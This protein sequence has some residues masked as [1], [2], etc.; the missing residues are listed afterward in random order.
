[1]ACNADHDRIYNYLRGRMASQEKLDF[2]RHLKEC[3]A[4]RLKLG[5][6]KDLNTWLADWEAPEPSLGFTTRL[7]AR[8]AEEKKKSTS[9]WGLSWPVFSTMAAVGIIVV[10]VLWQIWPAMNRIQ[11]PM[12]GEIVLAE[13]VEFLE[14]LELLQHWEMLENWDEIS[15]LQH[16]TGD[17]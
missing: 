1:M 16:Q 12:Q 3:E 15:A 2:E 7:Q 11:K 17:I 8:L 4:C 5:Q 9:W 14:K 10:A 13:N 6:E